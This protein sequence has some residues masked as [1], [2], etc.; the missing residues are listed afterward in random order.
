MC[1]CTAHL[2]AVK[3]PASAPN[4]LFAFMVAAALW[5]ALLWRK[6]AMVSPVSL[7]W[8]P[9]RAIGEVQGAEPKGRRSLGPLHGLGGGREQADLCAVLSS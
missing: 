4:T 7:S 8:Y 1:K 5:A 2:S 6:K 9:S 3:N